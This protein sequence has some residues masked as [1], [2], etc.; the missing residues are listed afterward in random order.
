VLSKNPSGSLAMDL[1]TQMATFVRIVEAGSLSAAARAARLSLPAVSRQLRALEAELGASLAVRTT[2]A[3]TITDAGRNWYAACVRVL[4]DVAEAK[5]AAGAPDRVEGRLVISAPHTL[6]MSHVLPRTR[7]LLAKHP[8]L[9]VDL[10]F[11]DHLVNLVAEGVDIAIR[12]GAM[13]PDSSAVVALPFVSFRRV[14]V[15]APSYLRKHPAPKEPDDLRRHVSLVQ[16]GAACPLDTWNLRR[17]DD[18]RAVLVTA[19]FRCTTPAA[20]RDAAVAGMGVA[21]LPDWLVEHDVAAGRLR[22]LLPSWTSGPVSA[23]VLFRVDARRSPTVRA[24]LDELRI[25]P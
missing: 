10:R 24:F 1:L 16:L 21:L 9:T 20:I 14:V 11:E 19:N 15:A 3:L 17:L 23:W 7:S 8:R 6:G 12:G 22:R 25:A 13:P 4:R 18:E 5:S 2:R